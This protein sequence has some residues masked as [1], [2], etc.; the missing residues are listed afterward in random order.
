M[1]LQ[2]YLI[3]TVYQDNSTWFMSPRDYFIASLWFHCQLQ[4]EDQ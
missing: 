1:Q 2:K 3:K 4:A